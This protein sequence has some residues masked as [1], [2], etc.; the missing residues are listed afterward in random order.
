MFQKNVHM[1]FD[2]AVVEVQMVR[3]LIDIEWSLV[4]GF[5]DLDPVLASLLPQK[6]VR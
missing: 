6:Q 4:Q 2:R 5:N 1:M 3:Q